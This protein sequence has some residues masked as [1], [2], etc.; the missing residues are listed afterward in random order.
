MKVVEIFKSI[1][2]EGIRAGYPATFIRLFGCNLRCSYCDTPYGYEGND[3]KEM[4]VDE[5]VQECM[6]LNCPR[7]TLTGGEPLIHKDVNI[8]IKNLLVNGF[9]VNIETNGSVDVELLKFLYPQVVITMDWKCPS[10]GCENK[11]SIARL[12]D[13]KR[14][15]VLKFVV[16]SKEDLEVCK[17]I[18]NTQELECSIFI[19]PI[20][21]KIEP[22]EIVD[23]MLENNMMDCRVQLQMHKFIW[24]PNKRGV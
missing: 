22:S 1:D 17:S 13:L 10:S 7:I 11:M 23:Y 4:T 20:F 3:Y 15:D 21:G 12:K 19:S 8:L 9:E 2:G 5:I 14:N 18:Y 24:N 16:G 6:C